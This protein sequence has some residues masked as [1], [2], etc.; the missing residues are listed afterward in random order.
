M[1]PIAQ[2]MSNSAR[3][4]R[5]VRVMF[6]T[7]RPRRDDLTLPEIH[8]TPAGDEYHAYYP[9]GKALR[10][11]V[12]IY[13]MTID[14]ERDGRLLK[15]ARACANAGLRVIVPHLPGLMDFIVA[16]GD[17]QRLERIL[18]DLQP[19]K[20][21]R[22]A[23]TGFST[24]GSYA[25]L[26]AANPTLKEKIGPLVLISP[27]YDARDVA[28]RL[29]APADPPPQNPKEWDQFYWAQYVIAYR[30]RV[31]LSLPEAVEE[32]LQIFLSDYDHYQ[33]DVKRVF[34]NNHIA[35]YH[36]SERTDLLYENNDLDLLSARGH[37]AAVESPVFIMHDAADRVVP[38]DHSRRMHAELA[39]RGAAFRQGVLVTPWLSHVVMQTTGSP[40]EL[41]QFVTYMSELF[42]EDPGR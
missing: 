17:L 19:E 9:R 10:T 15:F 5:G 36:L 22:L 11:V 28:D 20:G 12:L 6:R 16:P 41:I 35:P 34:Y 1:K 24:G 30:N 23:L 3:L 8:K 14:G 13:G 40:A 42:R 39:Q 37:L 33:V 26:L 38:P 27:I 31:R 21:T 32:A 29:H 4:S 25:L 2:P 7:M 18:A